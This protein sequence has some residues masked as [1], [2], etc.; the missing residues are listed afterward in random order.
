MRAIRHSWKRASREAQSGTREHLRGLLYAVLGA[1]LWGLSGTAA[2][3]L[4][5]RHGITPQWLVAARML[6]AGALLAL[7]ARPVFPR[8]RLAF[9]LFF[10]IVG[11]AGVQYT[12]FAAIAYGN[13]ATAT[14][15][16]SLSVP[17]IAVY[18]A[19]A[20]R[21]KPAPGRLIAIGAALLGTALLVL[22][23]QSN[24]A[25]TPV[26]ALGVIFGILSAVVA[27]F[28]ILASVALVAEFGTW[29]VTAWGFLIGG[30]VMA[31]WAPPWAAHPS[32][33][34][35]AV[36]LL[37]AFVVLFGTLAAFGLF[38]GSLRYI[39]ATEAGVAGTMEPVAASVAAFVFLHVALTPIQYV[40]GALILVAVALL[41]AGA[42]EG[43]KQ[44]GR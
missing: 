30:L 28:Y 12:Y 16:Q 35:I 32:G 23:G 44:N 42:K 11:L 17:M 3:V 33:N 8:R 4:F 38:L 13:A 34:I 26:S 5:Q 25:A 14:L 31:F 1:I 19:V 41:R 36:V 37:T 24:G 39:P 22:G 10:A 2:Q 15:L 18:E 27:A 6:G 40:G 20:A 29:S 7:W 9:F 21:H 43:T